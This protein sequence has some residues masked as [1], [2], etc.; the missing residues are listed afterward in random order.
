MRR[1]ASLWETAGQPLV[2]NQS[3]RPVF[4]FKAAHPP[5]SAWAS[6]QPK[7][8]TNKTKNEVHRGMNHVMK[9]E[10]DRWARKR[11]LNSAMPVGSPGPL[12]NMFSTTSLI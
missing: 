7:K 5:P 9:W 6:A 11:Y 2:I 8:K 1:Q 3:K 4:F 12:Q 10:E